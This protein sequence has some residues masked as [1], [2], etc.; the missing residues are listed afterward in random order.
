[1]KHDAAGRTDPQRVVEI[2]NDL[3]CYLPRHC[4]RS[5]AIHSSFM[6]LHGFA[7]LRSQ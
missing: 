4:E 6:P 5:E 2:G 3:G 7:S 1:V